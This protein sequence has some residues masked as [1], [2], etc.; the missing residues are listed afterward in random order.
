MWENQTIDLGN[1]LEKSKHVID[2]KYKGELEVL[3]TEASCGC[4]SV[5]HIPEQNIIRVTYKAGRVPKHLRY[6]GSFVANK[7]IKVITPDDVHELVI[8]V[9]IKMKY[10]FDR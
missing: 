5:V 3:K 1:I 8:L 4:T 10:F 7:K 2:F 9:T 6:K